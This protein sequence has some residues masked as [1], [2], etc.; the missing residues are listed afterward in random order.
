MIPQYW[1]IEGGQSAT[2]GL[3]EHL[4]EDHAIAPLL[5]NRAV[6]Q[7]Q[8]TSLTLGSETLASVERRAFQFYKC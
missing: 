8:L 4:V 5:G 1:L 6:L 3:L 2:G 7:S